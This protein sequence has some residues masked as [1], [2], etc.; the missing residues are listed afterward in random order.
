MSA[1]ELGSFPRRR[2]IDGRDPLAGREGR[3]FHVLRQ[4]RDHVQRMRDQNCP[5]SRQQV[6]YHHREATGGGRRSSAT[7][8]SFHLDNRNIDRR[9]DA[10]TAGPGRLP[11]QSHR[12]EY[13]ERPADRAAVL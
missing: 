11:G 3:V 10:N 1:R 6:I 2:G 9:N 13:H 5:A 4:F 8:R 7:T 12:H